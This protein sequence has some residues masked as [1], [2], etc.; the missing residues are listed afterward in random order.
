MWV[1]TLQVNNTPD[2]AVTPPDLD[3][4]EMAFLP[5]GSLVFSAAPKHG[6]VNLF[7][8]DLAGNVHSLGREEARYPAVSDDGHW[9]AYSRQQGG[10][11][12]LWLR[13]FPTGETHRITN[14]ECNDISPAWEADSKTLVYAS[15]CG[16][17]LWLTA[18][19][20]QQVIP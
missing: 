6:L 12:N 3:V 2:I 10:V 14:A 7:T 11:W 16:R 19:V 17:A 8:V 13:E 1:R 18:L 4:R 9:L 5:D 20:R 15:D